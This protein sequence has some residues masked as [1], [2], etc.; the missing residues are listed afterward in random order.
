M[1]KLKRYYLPGRIYFITAVTHERKNILFENASLFWKAV[2]KIKQS[3]FFD[4]NAW[5]LMPEHLHIIID[6]DEGSPADIIK[7]IKL[8]FAYYYR[9]K[10]N[11]YRGQVWQ[12]RFWDHIIRDREDMNRHIDYIHYNPVRHGLVKS[13]F[14]WPESLIHRYFEDGYYSRDWGSNERIEIKGDFGE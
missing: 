11:L 10:H 12:S 6:P 14:D 9:N 2:E 4:L 3:I 8:S 1:S 5:V 13:P 7:R